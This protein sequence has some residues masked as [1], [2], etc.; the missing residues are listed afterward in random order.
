MKVGVVY[1]DEGESSLIYVTVPESGIT[2]GLTLGPPVGL[3]S[4]VSG[5]APP[6]CLR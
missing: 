1:M 5:S 6:C 3:P 2:E 4:G